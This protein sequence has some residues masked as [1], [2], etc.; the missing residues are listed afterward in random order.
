MHPAS[1]PDHQHRRLR[2]AARPAGDADAEAVMRQRLLV[3]RQ[4]ERRPARE[5]DGDPHAGLLEGLAISLMRLDLRNELDADAL[6]GEPD[7]LALGERVEI[8]PRLGM[9][10]GGGRHGQH[11]RKQRTDQSVKKAGARHDMAP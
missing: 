5:G 1:K 6:A 4:Y 8:A 3:C 7:R 9:S 10:G 2:I 11:R